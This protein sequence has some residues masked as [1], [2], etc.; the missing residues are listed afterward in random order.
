M[1]VRV[2]LADDQALIR[3][4][5]R[6]LIESEPGLD[7]AGEAAD[8]GQAVDQARALLPDVVLM[9]IRMPGM[10]GLE[11]TR[12]I[13]AD[14][15]LTG[16]KVVVLTTF[17]QDEYVLT[18]LK[19]GASGF[20]M[21][22]TAPEELLSAI[23]T[24]AAGDSLLLPQR[25]RHLVEKFVPR[26]SAAQDEAV[27]P[28]PVGLD[29]LSPREREVLALVG[30]GHSNDEIAALL[31]V[32]PLTAKTH[33]SRVMTKLTARDRAQLVVIAYE[34]GLLRPGREG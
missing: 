29:P 20:M 2:L 13:C 23:R 31:H 9:D 26:E 27:P 15:A 3:G 8:G 24:V 6:A 11:A 17:G 18:A 16:V 34:S 12:E 4:G 25:T 14:P 10:D 1:T 21:K 28:E 7:V 19:A 5:L 32:S 22:D 30:R 33:V